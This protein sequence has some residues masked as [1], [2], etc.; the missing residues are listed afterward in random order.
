MVSR[1]FVTPASV[2]VLSLL[3]GCGEKAAENAPPSSSPAAVGGAT[4][5]ANSPSVVV[6][7]PPPPKPSVEQIERWAVAEFEPLRLLACR[8]GFADSAVQCLALSADGKQFV[9]GGAK[10]TVWN[11]TDEKPAVE[12]LEKYKSD[13]VERPIRAVAISPDGKWLA[14]GDEKG[15]VRVWTISDQKEVAVIKAHQGH[16][17]QVA[18]APNSQSLATTGYSGEVILWQ[19]PDGKKL[20]SIPASKQEIAR[21]VFLSDDLLATAGGGDAV[22]W[23]VARGEKAK[24]LR[25]KYVTG[26]ALGLSR[27]RSKLAFSESDSVIPVWDVATLK[28]T[29]IALHG[30]AHFVE[31]SH[32]GTR[33]AAYS[34]STVSIWDANSG[35][36]LQVIDC[37]GGE[38]SALAWHP[39]AEALVVASELGRVRIWGSPATAKSI[40]IEPLKLPEVETPI[41]GAHQSLTP[42]Q[43]QRVIDVRSFPQL[44]G[45][46]PKWGDYDNNSYVA[47][48]SQNEAEQFYRYYLDKAGWK[49]TAPPAGQLGLM[50]RKDD[51]ELSVSF[52]PADAAGAGAASDLQV[53]LR[54]LGNYDARWLPRISPIDSRSAYS[55]FALDSYR[56]RAAMTDVE[57]AILKQFHAA[58]WTAYTR[59]NASSAEEPDSRRISMLQGGSE[60]TVSIGPPAD[61]PG[62][63]DVQVSARASNKS[64]PIP[65]DSGWIE[66]DNSTDLSM[67][68]NTKMD[69]KQTAQFYDKQ[70]AAEGWLAREAGRHLEDDKAWL[71]YI[72]GQQDVLLRLT[73]LT[74]GGTRVVVGDAATT[75]WQLQKSDATAEKGTGEKADKPGIEA[76]DF[77]LPAGARA[78]KFDVDQKNIEYEVPDMT[79]T[80]LGELFVAQMEALKW[81]RDGA[82]IVGDDYTFITFKQGKGEIKIRARTADKKATAMI[83]GD[84][85]LWTKPLPTAPVRISYETWLRRGRRNA[86]LDLLDEFAAEMQKIPAAVKQK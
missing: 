66:F 13:E 57:V 11:V 51:C 36:V 26:T 52:S 55:S 19:L 65:P 74:G 79:A 73:K 70:M 67:V 45:A 71:S 18:F 34:G 72:R 53:D 62:E 10:L 24:E 21:M 64:L 48:A 12:M 9:L 58:G 27:D 20:K 2:L 33:L 68:A 80:K 47:R 31:F 32:D 63:W 22:I 38:I 41:A 16:I 6:A 84:G 59:L 1:H 5:A 69:L 42:A 60:L 4:P 43:F 39:G 35:K 23:N 40:G 77:A 83:G 46:V 37:D 75:S 29:G 78:V 76:A 14:A 82:G 17:S 61:A 28:P 25:S 56:T 49:E 30:G 81:T 15:A 7:P 3:C 86:T 44:P 85:L 8:D 50:F 54:F